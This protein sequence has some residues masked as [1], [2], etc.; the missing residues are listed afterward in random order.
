MRK[1]MIYVVALAG[2]VLGGSVAYTQT[3]CQ[4]IGRVTL[5]SGSYKCLGDYSVGDCLWTD[6][7]RKSVE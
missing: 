7:C 1:T 5:V 2:V 3:V 6:D 4:H